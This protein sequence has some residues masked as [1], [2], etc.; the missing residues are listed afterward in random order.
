MLKGTLCSY[1]AREP[2]LQMP[3]MKGRPVSM[4]EPVTSGRVLCWPGGGLFGSSCWECLSVLQMKM[5]SKKFS[6]IPVYT[7]AGFESSGCQLP[8]HANTEEAPSE[9][10]PLVM[11]LMGWELGGGFSSG[12]RRAE[13][14]EP[15][16]PVLPEG[17]AFVGWTLLCLA[18]VWGMQRLGQDPDSPVLPQIAARAAVA[19]RGGG[20]P[21]HV[22]PRLCH[23]GRLPPTAPG[24][25]ADVVHSSR[26]S[27]CPQLRVV[28]ARPSPCMSRTPGHSTSS[29][30]LWPWAAWQMLLKVPPDGWPCLQGGAGLG[31]DQDKSPS[32]DKNPVLPMCMYIYTYVYMLS[33]QPIYLYSSLAPRAHAR[34]LPGRLFLSRIPWAGWEQVFSLKDKEGQVNSSTLRGAGVVLVRGPW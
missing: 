20:V 10:V 19:E 17:R 21:A 16:V 31:L 3:G 15:G 5:P 33:T 7:L 23:E 30:D 22:H 25:V 14:S 27:G 28:P 34:T 4:W 12:E 2:Y 6:H 29:D 11:F 13:W 32:W 24:F 1:K 9:C 18:W 8:N 26:R